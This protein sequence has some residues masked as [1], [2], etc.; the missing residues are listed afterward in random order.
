[1]TAGALGIIGTG[2]LGSAV[3][4]LAVS[5]GLNVLLA[6]SRGPA[7]LAGLVR[8][9]GHR[10]RAATSA[11]VAATTATVVVAVPLHA[12]RELPAAE[13]AGR[14]VLDTMNYVRK[15]NGPIAELDVGAVASSTLVQRHLAGSAVVKALNTIDSRRLQ[16][17]ARPAGDPER[18]ALPVAGDHDGAVDHAVALLDRLGYDAVV[19]GGLADSRCI[20]P[21]TPAY[22]E[23]YRGPVPHGVDRVSWLVEAPGTPVPAAQLR[24]LVAA[25]TGRST[26]A[27]ASPPRKV[28][29]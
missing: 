18:S 26:P 25:G 15:W 19:V 3:A 22:G 24:E 27:A 12:R 6:N 2:R 20:E 29:S 11:E 4:R 21:G 8:E 7:T 9:L 14:A 10:A 16:L 28:F 5:A 23:P 17:L 1:V 13:L